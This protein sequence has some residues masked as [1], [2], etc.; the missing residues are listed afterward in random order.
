MLFRSENVQGDERDTIFISVGY[1][2][3][4]AGNL[5]LN[6]GPLNREGGERRL[7]VVVTRAR[8][9]IKL[10]SSIR[11]D[12][13]DL[14]RSNQKGIKLLKEYLQYAEFGQESL[15]KNYD[16][17]DTNEAESFFEEQVLE[18]LHDKGLSVVPQVGSSKFRIDIAVKDPCRSGRF[19]LGIE[20]DGATYHSSKTARDR[21]RL[22]QE[23]LE[24][25]GWN[26]HR[27]W[28]RDWFRNPRLEIDKVLQ[29][30]HELQSL[31]SP[32]DNITKPKQQT[33]DIQSDAE[34]SSVT[35]QMKEQKEDAHQ[36]DTYLSYPP[37]IVPYKRAEMR[38]QDSDF[39]RVTTDRHISVILQVVE[40]EGPIVVD[41]L[42]SQVADAYHLSRVGSKVQGTLGYALKKAISRKQVIKVEDAICLPIQTAIPIRRNTEQFSRDITQI[43]IIELSE[44]AL[45]CLQNAISI[46]DEELAAAV[47]K[48]FGF[49][50]SG[51]KIQK[52][53]MDGIKYLIRNKRVAKNGETLRLS[54]T[55]GKSG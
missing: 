52:R 17:N 3:D 11:A 44:A 54:E 50:R 49:L 22:R 48:L 29:R 15:V 51:P 46:K 25:L 33:A 42:F 8:D 37:G 18:A 7:N 45:F 4:A 34:K 12:E 1:G 13:I 6:F 30:L 26:I 14:T 55:S 24:N 43:P 23:I 9:H 53:A 31:E 20:C 36:Q 16:V 38:K 39:Y 27:I 5:A 32:D 19:I 40:Q 41:Y 10:V 28:S 2:K 47:A 21:D 35:K